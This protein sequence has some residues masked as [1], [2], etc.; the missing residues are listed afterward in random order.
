M[1]I[2]CAALHCLRDIKLF[3]GIIGF[4]PEQIS[5][6]T[7]TPTESFILSSIFFLLYARGGGG[8]FLCSLKT[9]WLTY[10]QSCFPYTMIQVYR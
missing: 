2:I 3:T 6:Q 10:V 5:T 4:F 9:Q 1:A 7:H 8:L